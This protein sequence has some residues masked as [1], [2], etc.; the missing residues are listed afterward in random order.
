MMRET[1]RFL[2]SPV[3]SLS[4]AVY[5]LA[6]SALVSSILALVRDRLFAHQFGAG[7]ELDIYYA[8]F[9]IPDLIFVAVGSL[10][11]VYILIPELAR[12]KPEEQRRYIDTVIVG[13][14]AL[15]ASLSLVA[16]FL[17]PKLLSAL[18]PQ[19]IEAGEFS[20][21]LDLTRIML[22]Q[23]IL[24]G[25]SNILASITQARERYLLYALSPILYNLGIIAGLLVLYPF[26]GMTGLAW[27]VVV[28]ACMH[29][30]IQLPSAV[31]DGFFAR[32]P[33]FHEPRMFAETI[34]I[35][36]PRTL[37]LSMNQVSFLGLTV[38]AAAL[39]QG[40]IA[41]FMFAFNLMSVPLAIIG[42]SYS[43]AAF[44][45]LASALSSGRVGEFL[46]FVSTAARYVIFWSLPA[47]AL[48]VVLRAHV[49]RVVLGSGAFDW[50][51]TRLTAA[52][53]ALLSLSLA[54]QGLSL[55]ITRAYYAAGRTFVPFV[56]AI[57]SGV[58]TI[59]LASMLITVFA[60]GG[61]L[62]ILERIMRLED[63][64]GSSVLAL[65]LAYAIAS[66]LATSVLIFVFERKYAGFFSRIAPALWQ[67]TLAACAAG[68]AAYMA[69]FMLG[70]LTLSPTLLS[71]FLRGSAGG[72]AG[73]LAAA[74]V[75]A[76]LRNREFMET[77]AVV[78]NRLW[79][80]PT[81]L[82]KPISSAEEVGPSVSQ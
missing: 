54:V 79:K 35:S 24:L 2:A 81:P 30:A 58:A 27:G 9:R 22:L 64:P 8:A 17:A 48:I 68:S 62:G 41:V 44:P 36:I 70:P 52:V 53:F 50:T 66:L 49:V 80:T 67:G 77:I 28:G 37:A 59:F 3:R 75:Y 21:L 72:V 60:N 43:V 74:L 1:L 23:P 11:S 10:V 7:V 34:G 42:A 16:F 61:V 26:F 63:V 29:V 18:F 33:H 31:R 56:I 19:F 46:E 73:I 40:S 12:R 78:Q 57:G 71:V 47:I 4:G 6:A 32:L 15:A 69:L 20:V 5:V 14:S 55:L 38:L 45:T 51:D 65:P 76:L 82:A 39:S 13:F 25:L